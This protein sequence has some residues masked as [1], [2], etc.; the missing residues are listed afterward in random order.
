[1]VQ[2]GFGLIAAFLSFYSTIPRT[3]ERAFLENNPAVLA[4]LFSK[5]S[6]LLISLPEPMA[7][8]DMVTDEQAYWV[9]ER[10]FRSFRTTEFFSVSDHP[11][12]FANGSFIMKSR[13]ALIDPSTSEPWVLQVFL[14]IRPGAA[15]HRKNPLWAITEIKAEKI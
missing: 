15:P 10:F 4:S 12:L 13:W 1:M 11:P 6:P 5:D 3:V 14:F 8:S 9:F 2:L 7:F